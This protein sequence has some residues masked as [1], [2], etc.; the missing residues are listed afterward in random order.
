M[1]E[2]GNLALEVSYLNFSPS[3]GGT[4]KIRVGVSFSLNG[5]AFLKVEGLQSFS[6]CAM[7]NGVLKSETFAD[8]VQP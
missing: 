5:T 2:K 7:K 8:A 3:A 6:E 4:D 1:G